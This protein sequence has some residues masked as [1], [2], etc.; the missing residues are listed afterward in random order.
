MR[1][2]L[3]LT[4]S[5][6]VA[7]TTSVVLSSADVP[8][9]V[10]IMGTE[11]FVPNA[12]IN[13]DFRFSPGPLSV[14]SGDTV[15]WQNATTDGHTISI[16]PSQPATVGDVFMCGAPGTVCAPIL[17]CHFPGGFG[18]GGPPPAINP[19][20]GNAANGQLSAVGDSFLIPPPGIGPP[21][22]QT[23]T[24][25]ITA[26]AGTTLLYMCVIHPWMQGSIVVH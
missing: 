17:Q 18:N 14:K 9:N 1:R 26:P 15:T 6:L 12:L 24:A 8:R 22:L 23:V 13:A 4:A 2:L 3:V 7:L 16:V 20:C 25:I 5:A 10:T 21:S 19:F 11:H